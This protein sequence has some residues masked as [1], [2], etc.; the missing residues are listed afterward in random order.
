MMR[1]PPFVYEPARSIEHAV[2]LLA[3]HGTE[4]MPVSGGTDLYAN[5][6]QR[7]FTPRVVVG[8]RPI[9]SLRFIEY[10]ETLGLRVG[11]LATLSDVANHA[12][13]RAHYAALASAAHA[14]S[15]PQ[16]R[17]MGTIGGN[18]CVDTRCNYYNQN[19][20]WRKALGYCMKKDGD[21]CRVALS[22]PRCVA[23]NS[24]DTAPVLIALGATI[25]VAGKAGVREIP[26][27][28][29]FHNDGMR[30]WAL[31]HGD[32]VTRIT[33][34][35]P[36]PHTRSAY[37]KLRL[38][39]SFDFPILGVAAMLRTDDDGVCREARLVL[40]AVA[41]KPLDVPAAAQA[42]VGSRLGA[43]ALDAAA[44]A[45]YA[46]GKPLDNTSATIPYRKRMVR[47]FARRA[48]TAA[49]GAA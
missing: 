39:N 24:S 36:Q 14:V 49:L 37:A 20:D 46:M 38:R 7:L 5:M 2:E 25:H 29:F 35:A 44:E 23:V 6:K 17:N 11:A 47:V 26:A 31:D 19:L 40:N 18:L 16:L 33:I 8:L 1:L 48:L 3:R 42:L 43:D 21:V 12:A 45:A 13:V 30:A 32:L 15:T 28:S 10:D 4:A 34:P 41:S 22:S 9:E 27:A